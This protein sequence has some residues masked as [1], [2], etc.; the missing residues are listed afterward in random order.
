MNETDNDPTSSETVDEGFI[1]WARGETLEA[2]RLREAVN[3]I[4]E[5]EKSVTDWDDAKK[6]RLIAGICELAIGQPAT[7]EDDV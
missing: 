2:S 5:I 3:L 6:L 1:Q 7:D 4:W